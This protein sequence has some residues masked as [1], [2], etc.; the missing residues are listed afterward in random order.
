MVWA[1]SRDRVIGSNGALPWHLPE[2]MRR[3]RELTSGDTVVM[4]RL[5][6]ESL[7]ERFRPLPGRRNI[8]LSRDPSYDAAGAEVLPSLTAALEAVPDAWVIGGAAVYREALPHAALVCITDVDVSVEGDVFAPE[9]GSE[10]R[11]TL[12]H[13]T[14]GWHTSSSGLR[15]RWRELQ[16]G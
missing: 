5:T 10:W 15:F 8:V 12:R 11:E 9:L 6:W 14:D 7:P 13:P 3:F 1:Q 2:D 16:R 4:G